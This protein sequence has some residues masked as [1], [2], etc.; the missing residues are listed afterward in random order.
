[1]R[2]APPLSLDLERIAGVPLELCLIEQ[3]VP[4][5]RA[6]EDSLGRRIPGQRARL[7]TRLLGI[8]AGEEAR[9][10]D[11]S[12]DDPGRSETYD[13]PIVARRAA[14]ARLPPVHPLPAL[15]VRALAPFGRA[16]LEQVL[17]GR[18]KLV[19]R[20]DDDAAESLGGEVYEVSKVG[21]HY[22]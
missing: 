13:C 9:V 8:I 20:G 16:G 11:D 4:M 10:D 3:R 6:A 12:P 2:H 17:L 18:E 5:H 15:C 14:P 1:M 21:R 7:D 22:W 19:V